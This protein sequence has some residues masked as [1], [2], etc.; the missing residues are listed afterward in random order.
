[1]RGIGG[2]WVRGRK[3]GTREHTIVGWIH[4][5]FFVSDRCACLLIVVLRC[6]VVLVAQGNHTN[7]LIGTR[8][9]NMGGA[10]STTQTRLEGVCVCM[11]VTSRVV[12]CACVPL[13]CCCCVGCSRSAVCLAFSPLPGANSNLPQCADAQRQTN[14]KKKG[15]TTAQTQ[16]HHQCCI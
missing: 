2:R 3:G 13:L 15:R 11:C 12:V 9:A 6:T 1:M 16:K 14:N 7:S 8:P 4:N 10:R 5:L